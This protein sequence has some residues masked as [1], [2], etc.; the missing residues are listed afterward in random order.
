MAVPKDRPQPGHG[1]PLTAE[2]DNDR[3]LMAQ[4]MSNHRAC[5]Q[6]GV[7]PSTGMQWRKV[8]NPFGRQRQGRWKRRWKRRSTCS[9][10]PSTDAHPEEYPTMNQ[11]QT[12][13]LI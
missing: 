3:W 4:G 13:T 9:R 2:R 6:I 12:Q 11:V 10:S 8:R 5:L 7:L 1:A